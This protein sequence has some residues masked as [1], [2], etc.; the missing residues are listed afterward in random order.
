MTRREE[1]DDEGGV[2]AARAQGFMQREKAVPSASQP[3]TL[4]RPD[5]LHTIVA[6]AVHRSAALHWLPQGPAERVLHCE[7]Q[8][9]VGV[10]QVAL[11]R[12]QT[13]SQVAALGGCCVGTGAGGSA[14]HASS[15]I[16]CGA[17]LGVVALPDASHTTAAVARHALRSVRRSPQVVG[18]ALPCAMQV[19]SQ[20]GLAVMH[21]PVARCAQM[22][23][24]DAPA[25]PPP[26]PEVPQWAH[27]AKARSAP[28]SRIARRGD[29]FI[30]A[31]VSP[32]RTRM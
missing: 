29:G 32:A 12:A 22:V 8:L 5:V 20:V 28:K 1:R 13:P 30:G 24:H 26:P 17:Q 31:T 9:A 4:P 10:G 14:T 11:T 3:R 6:E 7:T 2:C 19:D 18:T 27:H 23:E 15:A 16:C 25:E 21:I